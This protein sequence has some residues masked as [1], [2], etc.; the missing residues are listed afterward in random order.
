[1][2]TYLVVFFDNDG[3]LKSHE[4]AKAV[5][6]RWRNPIKDISSHNDII[7]I[8][9][10]DDVE[11]KFLRIVRASTNVVQYELTESPP[12]GFYDRPLE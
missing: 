7:F 10:K 12:P 1:M 4:L 11:D 9:I 6:G 5:G 8:D 3:D 2:K